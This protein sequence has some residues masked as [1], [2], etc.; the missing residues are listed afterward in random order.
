MEFLHTGGGPM[1]DFLQSIGAWPEAA[2]AGKWYA[3]PWAELLGAPSSWLLIHANFVTPADLEHAMRLSN[4]KPLNIAYCPR[5]HAAFGFNDYPLE[6]FLDAGCI[7]GLGTDSLASNPDL[8]VWNEAK[9]VAK[10][11][12]QIGG[13]RVFRMLTLDGARL[14]DCD[15]DL[16]SITPGKRADVLVIHSSQKGSRFDWERFFSEEDKEPRRLLP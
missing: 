6:L 14:L 13:E 7:V 8:D 3:D 1:K 10:K 12:P 9:F 2:P 15:D 16:G 4:G 11:F 5:T